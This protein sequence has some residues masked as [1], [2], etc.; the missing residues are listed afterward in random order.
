GE[1][2]IGLECSLRGQNGAHA[3]GD[4][5][6]V[7]CECGIARDQDRHRIMERRCRAYSAPYVQ[8]HLADAMAQG[9]LSPHGIS[10]ESVDFAARE[11]LRGGNA[12]RDAGGMRAW[13]TDDAHVVA[14]EIDAGVD[15]QLLESEF[16]HGG[17]PDGA[18]SDRANVARRRGD[19]SAQDQDPEHALRKRHKELAATPF[20]KRG[21]RDMRWRGN[22]ID[23]IV[24]QGLVSLVVREN[25]FMHNVE[26]FALEEIER[27][28]RDCREIGVGDEVGDGDAGGAQAAVSCCGCYFGT[29]LGAYTSAAATGVASLKAPLTTSR[30]ASMRAGSISPSG[31]PGTFASS[32]TASVSCLATAASTWGTSLCMIAPAAAGSAKASFMPRSVAATKRRTISGLLAIVAAVATMPLP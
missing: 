24:T 3:P 9:D 31:L 1:A 5:L 32:A 26:A 12:K 27:D 28:R 17:G 25:Q 19:V 21:E 18:A 16:D 7:V 29:N 23:L 8:Y 15:Q 14:H 11:S 6:G 30:V 13:Y 20:R 2:H 22:E 10:P 4:Q